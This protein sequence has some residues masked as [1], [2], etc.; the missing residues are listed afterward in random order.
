M[1]KVICNFIFAVI[2]YPCL[3]AARWK[4]EQKN[5]KYGLQ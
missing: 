3:N 1:Q 5:T 2:Y 4:I